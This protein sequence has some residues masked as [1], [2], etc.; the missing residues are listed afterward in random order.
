[1]DL[2]VGE[3]MIEDEVSA[4]F[5]IETTLIPA[6]ENQFE[7]VLSTL[8]IQLGNR[9]REMIEMYQL[10]NLTCLASDNG[11][12]P[13]VQTST[14]INVEHAPLDVLISHEA[15]SVVEGEQMF[16]VF[17]SAISYPPSEIVWK[18]DED[19]ISDT[20][21]LNFN[22]PV[23]RFMAGEYTCEAT[24]VHGSTTQSVYIDVQYPPKCTVSKE[25]K[26]EEITL[27]CSAVGNPEEFV[28]WWS[29]ENTTFEG[30]EDQDYSYVSLQFVNESSLPDYKC[31]VNN[32]AG[33]SQPCSIPRDVGVVMAGPDFTLLLVLLVVGAVILVI[34]LAAW[35]LSCRNKGKGSP[36]AVGGEGGKG[37]G[38]VDDQPHPDSNF[39][40]NLPFQGLKNPPKKVLNSVDDDM[41]YADVDAQETYSYGPLNYK[42]A[43]LQKLNQKKKQEAANNKINS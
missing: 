35:C 17:C 39:Y 4:P 41:V 25:V 22:E 42:S 40:D 34:L 8:Y 20:V 28:Y 18:I 3:E 32:T 21:L 12:G 43:S 37:K 29:Y 16:P 31:F 9:T 36:D 7:S 13:S 27:K 24:N 26:E 23:E 5:F 1:V 15:V 11:I 19:I 30:Q 10:M 38:Q 14:L 2:L 33:K 6:D